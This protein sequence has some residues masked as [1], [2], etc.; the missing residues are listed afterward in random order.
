MATSNLDFGLAELVKNNKEKIKSITPKNPTIN[1]DDE[2]WDDDIWDK[3]YDEQI[4]RLSN[5]KR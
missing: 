2:W 1:K 3:L 5:V 4:K